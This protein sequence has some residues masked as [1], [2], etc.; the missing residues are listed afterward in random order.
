MALTR[1]RAQQILN[2]DIKQAVRVVTTSNI[3]LSGGAPGIVDEVTLVA[4]NRVLVNG[5]TDA[6]QNGIY[7]VQS[8][9]SNVASTG[10]W[11]RSS[12]ANV[13][14]EIASGLVVTVSEG[15]TFK[16]TLWTLTT[17]DPVIIGQSLISFQQ[18]TS[19]SFGVINAGG[20]AI[21]A[22]TVGDT[23]TFSAGD[24]IA[25][26]G[27]ANSKTVTIGVSGIETS[28]ISNGTS[29]VAIATANG[30][31]TVSVAGTANVLTVGSTGTVV[32]GTSSATGNIT[33]GN[34]L[35][36]A[37]VIASGVIES[38]TG[39]STGGYLSVDGS[40]DL[41]NTTVYGN[42]SAT[43]TIS[44]GGITL[45]GNLIVGAGPTLTIDPNGSGGTDGNVV[46]TGNLTVNGTTTTINSNTITT[47]DLQIN[48]ANNAATATAANNGGIG[49]GPA[50]AE[51]ATFLYNTA[52][53][54]WIASLGISSVGN[55]TGGN[56]IGTNVTG[57]LTTAAQTNITSV[58]TLTSASI[59][60]NV[61]GGNILTAG[62]ISAAGSITGASV[63]GG[64]IT[65]TST[66][67]TGTTTA[68]SVVGGVITGTSASVTGNITGS[69]ILGNGS[70]LTGI[71]ASGGGITW[72][73]QA[74][75]APSSPAAG[76]FWYDSYTDKKYQ[77]TDDGV[78]DYWIDQSFPTSF[79]S[80]AVTGN[81]VAGNVLL[82]GNIVG[83]IVSQ[84]VTANVIGT[85]TGNVVGNVSGNLIG[86]SYG[87]STG[88]H[89][90]NVTG[91]LTGSVLTAAQPLIT[92]VGTLT[93]LAVTGNVTTDTFF[94]GNGSQLT[95]IAASY[96]NADVASNLAAFGSNPISTTGNITAGFILGNGIAIT[97]LTFSSLS[98]A[99]T[100]GLTVDEFY[101][102]AE[103]ALSVTNSGSSGYLFDQYSGTNPTITVT[104]GTTV[105]FR[106]AVT[107][108]PFLIQSSGANY[109]TGLN[110]V[111]T[112]GTVTTDSSAQ[113]KVTGTLYWKI[114]AGAAGN[115]TYQ[116]S[117][118]S[119]MVGTI[120]VKDPNVG[121]FTSV[122]VSGNIVNASANGVGN[123]GSATSFFNTV[124]AKATSAQYADLAEMYEADAA[125]TPGTVLVFGGG[126]EVTVSAVSHDPRT[127]GVVSTNP[128]YLMN[129]GLTGPTVVA[130]ALTGRVPCCVQG[131]VSKGDRLVNIAAGVAGRLDPDKYEVGSVIGKS[132][133]EICDSGQ[134]IIEIA[135]GRY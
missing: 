106:L 80:L 95:G 114:P 83:N 54:V 51:Y 8:A 86:N 134:H 85:V 66:S 36:G 132:L 1:I 9:G 38:G 64:V 100:A 107:G 96:G 35:T 101:L 19:F 60:G 131:P 113:G 112:T 7:Q 50:G 67:V 53:N 91:N 15:Y 130:V 128:S 94:L 17:D 81:I 63:V 3:T 33:G 104:A 82:T 73:T 59:S 62:L 122:S 21:L 2:I 79:S 105:A 89:T 70:Q 125:Y 126:H 24:N 30:N 78:S 34:I 13:T 40:S 39:L 48:M 133:E 99:N 116:C 46:I 41:H 87:N 65:G 10:T 84:T 110:H 93:S 23:F 11:V 124:H 6:T 118:H 117:I 76:D 92:S 108:H 49:V 90:G 119:G 12:D 120:T 28:E 75:S 74:N 77:Y 58:G 115:Y 123:I 4:G 42:L 55:I 71:A 129:S 98:D 44:V 5:Q 69:F 43:G 109:S 20:A 103:T 37:Q 31:V 25:I 16:D 68:A 72:T 22:N 27:N 111:T 56:L 88:T 14:G 121:V 26:T 47:N 127:A 32:L 29:T 102:S 57:T 97:G 61:Q 45:S 135:I 18:S 52:S